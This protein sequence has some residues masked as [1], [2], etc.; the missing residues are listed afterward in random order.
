VPVLCVLPLL[1]ECF[2][3]ADERISMTDLSA[4]YPS[5]RGRAVLITGGA[6]GIGASAVRHFANQ[7]SKVAFLDVQDDLGKKL[8]SEVSQ[9][10]AI[11]PVYEHCDLLDISAL[12]KAISNLQSRLGNFHVLVNNAANDDRH[13]FEDVTPEYWDQ[14]MAINLRHYFFAMQAVIPAMKAA[15]A[16]SII[17]MSS[18]GWMIPSVREVAYVTAKAAIVGLT[19]TM[20]HELGQWNIR[21]NAVLPGAILTE[22]QRA[23][24]WT[25]EYETE[26]MNSQCLKRPLLPEEV[27]SL[28]LFLAA[29]DSS[30]IT[31]QSSIVDAGW[32]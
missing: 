4:Q 9:S 31:N 27:A 22:R 23:L 1:L 20:A 6:S 24:W 26:I 17:N 28:L 15:K 19:R 13:N 3:N 8:L 18:I 11:T 25:P 21:V 10:G 5:L 32:V 2:K 29:D 7:G 16:G 30:A 14:R 12:Q